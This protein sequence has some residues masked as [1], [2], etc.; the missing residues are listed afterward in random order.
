MSFILDAL[1]KSEAERQRQ[2]VPGLLD[3][4]APLPRPRFPTWGIWIGALLGVNLLVLIILLLRGSLGQAPA[5][6]HAAANPAGTTAPVA[7]APAATAPVAAPATAPAAAPAVTA[8]A[9][10]GSTAAAPAYSAGAVAA[11][12][13]RP[14]SPMDGA[15]VY[16]PEI[17][18]SGPG[19]AAA[20]APSPAPSPAQAIAPPP[21]QAAVRPT[22]PPEAQLPEDPEEVVP[23]LQE[24]NLAGNRGIPELH[25]DIHVY[26][27]RPAD[28]F[29]FINNRKY[30]EGATLQE[31]PTV[32]R[33]TRDG[34]LLRYQNLRFSIP[35]Q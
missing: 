34:V 5:E 28:R 6:P 32:E 20:P 26:A 11:G 35:R 25:L 23:T 30:K 4:P 17:P 15:P 33:I 29:V 10:A 27:K 22:L 12:P 9:M 1:K 24:V 14:F 7:T 13:S 2:S 3:V 18:L 16:A 31:G 21:Q 8:S 19:A